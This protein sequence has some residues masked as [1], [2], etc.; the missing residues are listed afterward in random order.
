MHW[1][2]T[3]PE[4]A[5]LERLEAI[6]LLIASRLHYAKKT[7]HALQIIKGE[8]PKRVVEAIDGM[9]KVIDKLKVVDYAIREVMAQ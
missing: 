5:F 8:E 1:R 7:M 2:G 9:A 3:D 6:R 4:Q